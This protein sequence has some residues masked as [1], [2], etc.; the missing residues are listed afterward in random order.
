LPLDIEGVELDLGIMPARV[1][2]IEIGPPRG[3]TAIRLAAQ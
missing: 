3:E 2:A 1:Q